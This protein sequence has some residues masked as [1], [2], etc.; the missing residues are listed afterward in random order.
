MEKIKNEILVLERLI[1]ETYV[2]R[3]EMVYYE[4]VKSFNYTISE[5][6][7]CDLLTIMNDHGTNKYSLL[8]YATM[9]IYN[10]SDNIKGGMASD[11][12]DH[13]ETMAKIEEYTYYYGIFLQRRTIYLDLYSEF[14]MYSINKYRFNEIADITIDEYASGFNIISRVNYEFLENVSGDTFKNLISKLHYLI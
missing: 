10:L 8:S 1:D 11:S 4:N 6:G 7:T 5:K 3:A 13:Q 14:N 2:R 9:N 12:P